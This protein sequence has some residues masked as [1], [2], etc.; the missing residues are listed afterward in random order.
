[1]P[2]LV[3]D[4]LADYEDTG[5]TPDE[6]KALIK[7]RNE[8]LTLNDLREMDGEPVWVVPLI[9]SIA[10]IYESCWC[11]VRDAYITNGLIPTDSGRFILCLNE[12][13]GYG[14]DWIAYRR[15]QEEGTR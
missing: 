9:G 12:T 15:K 2:L 7:P 10:G 5:M 14:L 4:R 8:P 3:I 13:S 6:I 1:M 11:I